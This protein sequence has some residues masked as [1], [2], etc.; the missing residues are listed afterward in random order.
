MKY[1]F[2]SILCFTFLSTQSI[3]AQESTEPSEKKTI[4]ELGLSA[5]LTT[6]SGFSYRYWPGKFGVQLT[7]IPPL[8]EDGKLDYFNGG[9]SLLM[10][11]KD[12]KDGKFFVY[13]AGSFT[14]DHE[15]YTDYIPLYYD[16]PY[17]SYVEVP[18]KSI[19]ESIN[20]GIGLGFDIYAGKYFG[21]NLQGGY[22][23]RDIG[24]SINTIL[25]V[26]AG[27]Y[28]KFQRK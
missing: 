15:Y 13:A 3:V 28:Y 8:L 18:A 14:T 17:G 5:G 2:L 24:K 20:A 26:E 12:G 22:G 1:S 6:G 10:S 23:L 16:D 9:L 21:L 4:H 19:D 25:T 7:T 27:L 11:I